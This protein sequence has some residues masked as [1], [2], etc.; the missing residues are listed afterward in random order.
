MSRYS[1][2]TFDLGTQ[3]VLEE[4]PLVGNELPDGLNTSYNAKFV[5][6]L[7]DT[8]KLPSGWDYTILP[9][10]TGI[11]ALRDSTA[12]VWSGVVWDVDTVKNGSGVELSCTN[13]AGYYAYQTLDANMPFAATDQHTIARSLGQY[14][15]TQ[16][17]GD[18]G[19]DWGTSLSGIPRDR[20]EYLGT[21]HK[22]ILELWQGLAGVD[23]GIDFRFQTRMVG[24]SAVA[25]DFLVGS[26][27][28][29]SLEDSGIVFDFLRETGHPQG[30]NIAEYKVHRGARF[31]AVWALGAGSGADK[32]QV[33]VEDTAALAADFPRITKTLSYTSVAE[34][35]TL[36]GHALYALSQSGR[37]LPDITVISSE[38]PMI[39]EY[40]PGDFCR[41]EITSPEF[42]RRLGAPGFSTVA[43]IYDR[44]ID[45]KTDT[46]KIGLQL[47]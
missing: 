26:P 34:T 12:V 5:L 35:D 14:V 45:P 17:G 36:E 29:Q 9:G 20:L 38:F 33:Q 31:N 4:L 22:T 28:G 19:V 30:G 2:L 21:D 40:Q 16:A 25:H 42:P 6:P 15:D 3:L 13:L 41:V 1:Y 24:S 10:R 46:A 18:I 39:G 8:S 37:P 7:G 44:V 27:L 23:E 32:A 47:L 11:V 43:R